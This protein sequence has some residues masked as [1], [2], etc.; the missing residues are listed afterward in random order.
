MPIE[1]IKYDTV[2]AALKKDKPEP[3]MTLKKVFHTNKPKIN[4]NKIKRLVKNK[5][6]Y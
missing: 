2:T 5:R 1:I 3:K 6:N 4:K